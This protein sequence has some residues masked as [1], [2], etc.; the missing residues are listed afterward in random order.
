MKKFYKLSD[1][2]EKG[3]LEWANY[4]S[5]ELTFPCYIEIW[6]M[7]MIPNTLN[8]NLDWFEYIEVKRIPS[9]FKK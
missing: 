3:N 1:Y 4:S 8:L 2:T 9:K 6:D 7:P 5:S